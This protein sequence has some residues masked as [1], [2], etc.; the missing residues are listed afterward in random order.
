M[1][2]LVLTWTK[3][4]SPAD[5]VKAMLYFGRS[6]PCF[7]SRTWSRTLSLSRTILLCLTWCGSTTID[8]ATSLLLPEY[9]PSSLKSRGS[10]ISC[11]IQNNFIN[12]IKWNVISAKWT[13]WMAQILFS[14]DVCA[15]VLVCVCAQWTGQSDQFKT[16]KVADFKFDVLVPMGSPNMTP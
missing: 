3:K 11:D 5:A 1:L 7:W 16:V 13:E 10:E 8:S 14:F 12:V 2:V 4:H 9:W 15:Y 6:S